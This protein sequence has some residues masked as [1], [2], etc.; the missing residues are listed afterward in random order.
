M[1]YNF[2]KNC[3]H[4]SHGLY[5]DEEGKKFATRKGKTVFMKDILEETIDLAK[6]T[7]EEKNSELK[8]KEEIAR[9]IAIAAIFYGDLK[10]TRT[11]DMIF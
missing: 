3:I 10:N 7:I 11:N 6:I 9:K 4:V 2:S 1:G 8:N 5:L